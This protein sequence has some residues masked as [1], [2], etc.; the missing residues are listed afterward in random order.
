[1]EI[2]VDTS[3][4]YAVK[5]SSDKNHKTAIACMQ[6]LAENPSA[7]V[8]I[9]N[10]I[11][12]EVLTLFRNKLGFTSAVEFGEKIRSS[13]NTKKICVTEEIEEE[14]WELFKKYKD[15]DFSFTDCTSFI[16]M[17]KFTVNTVFAF[18]EH[19]KQIGYGF[20]IIPNRKS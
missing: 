1:M 11:F 15:K 7:V 2:F 10:Y 19:F 5:D 12:D 16:V 17:K 8:V 18:D 9:T 20:K 13:K 6:E 3:A 4:F 14:A